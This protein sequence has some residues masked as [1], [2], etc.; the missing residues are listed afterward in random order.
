LNTNHLATL[1]PVAKNRDTGITGPRISKKAFFQILVFQELIIAE[2]LQL[3]T[4]SNYESLSATKSLFSYFF[5]ST[6]RKSLF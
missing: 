3:R 2:N 6:S 4:K 1:H 5:L